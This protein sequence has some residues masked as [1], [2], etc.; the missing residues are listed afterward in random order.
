MRRARSREKPAVL[1]KPENKKRHLAQELGNKRV[2]KE[3]K[4]EQGYVKWKIIKL[5]I[6]I[7]EVFGISIY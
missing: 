3:K 1:Y 6:K 7:I 4:K 5:K 2:K